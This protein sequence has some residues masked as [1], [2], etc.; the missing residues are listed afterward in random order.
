MAHID[1]DITYSVRLSS[2]EFRLMTFAL[3]GKLRSKEELRD[4]LLLNER[5]C[6][7]RARHVAQLSEATTGAHSKASEL[8][9]ALD[10]Q[11]EHEGVKR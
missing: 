11:D 6:D 2:A 4:A 8:R 9:A 3:A 10:A 7:L 5:L 1:L